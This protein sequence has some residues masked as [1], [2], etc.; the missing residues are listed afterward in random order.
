[1]PL[2]LH[3]R[4]FTTIYFAIVEMSLLQFFHDNLEVYIFKIK[5]K[6]FRSIEKCFIFFNQPVSIAFWLQLFSLTQNIYN[7][8]HTSGSPEKRLKW[9]LVIISV[10]P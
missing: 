7:K 9:K 1:M 6:S 4:L 3:Y 5:L 8:L 2:Y 10:K